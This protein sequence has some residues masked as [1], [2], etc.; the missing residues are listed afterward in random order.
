MVILWGGGEGVVKLLG[1]EFQF[2][3]IINFNFENEINYSLVV[4]NPNQNM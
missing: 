2:L 1:F 4:S 3:K